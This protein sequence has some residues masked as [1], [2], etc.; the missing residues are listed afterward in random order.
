[1]NTTSLPPW[2]ERLNSEFNLDITH[3]DGD[4]HFLQKIWEISDP[5]KKGLPLFISENKEGE[6]SALLS[7]GPFC[8]ARFTIAEGYASSFIESICV[9]FLRGNLHLEKSSWLRV[10]YIQ[11]EDTDGLTAI[12]SLNQFSYFINRKVI[13]QQLSLAASG[14]QSSKKAQG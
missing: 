6:V 5:H 10:P 4:N 1:M 3:K 7:A 9:E 13:Q 2:L 14:Y 8:F 11:I 12:G